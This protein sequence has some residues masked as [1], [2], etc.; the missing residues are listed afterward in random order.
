MS[1]FAEDSYQ[2]IETPLPNQQYD[3]QDDDRDGVI[4]ARDLCPETPL[5]AEI[6]NDGCGTFVYSEE[7]IKMQVLFGEGSSKVKPVFL[8]QIRQLSQ[9]LDEYPSTA[10]TL[11][12]YAIRSEDG[13]YNIEL[14]KQRAE[15][16][17]QALSTY[18]TPFSRVK[19]IGYA[20]SDTAILNKEVSDVK[21]HAIADTLK[22]KVVATVVGYQGSVVREWDIFTTKP[23]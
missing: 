20:D 8:A 18:G 17:R 3:L 1:A 7:E 14:S 16:V 23:K 21:N 4:N 19:I 10:V 6:D 13:S 11:K 15:A 12:G 9:F 5:Q 2:D 22:R